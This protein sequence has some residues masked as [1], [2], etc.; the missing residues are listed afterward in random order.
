MDY[1]YDQTEEPAGEIS[2][3]TS[4]ANQLEL[5]EDDMAAASARLDELTRQRDHLAVAVI[6]E[7]MDKLGIEGLP[8]RDGRELAIK[9]SVTA[10]ISADRREAAHNWL[11]SA[12]FAD[13]IKRKVT[14]EFG[15]GQDNEAGALVD[16]LR[17]RG[18][19]P[20]DKSDVNY[21]TL[22]AFVRRRLAEGGELPMELLGVNRIR[23]AL[24]KEKAR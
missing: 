5:L 17:K 18:L 19:R 7:L 22:G 3:L 12:G 8:L 9:E 10:G 4:L 16:D 6:P 24:V 23:R 11:R 13:L 1:D 2:Q 20:D 21:Q 15:R 14:I